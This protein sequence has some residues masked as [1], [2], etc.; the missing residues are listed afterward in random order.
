MIYIGI[1]PDIDR[2]GWAWY[3]SETDK[4]FTSTRDINEIIE[5][6]MARI[7]LEFRVEAGWL[8]NGV[9]HLKAGMTPKVAAEVGRRVGQNHATGQMITK[10]L[11]GKKYL[12]KLVRPRNAKIKPSTF[13]KLTGIDTKNQEEIDA[14]MLLFDKWGKHE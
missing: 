12:V 4:L 1:D 3:N 2:S 14:A 10:I 6:D 11:T 7:G 5:T 13:K 9:F 8:N